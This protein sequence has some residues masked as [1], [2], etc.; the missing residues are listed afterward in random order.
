MLSVILLY[1]IGKY[2]YKLAE[3]YDKSQWSYAILGIAVFYAGAIIV[4]G[5]IM[6]IIEIF[7]PGF[8]DSYSENILG[9]MMMPFGALSCYLFYNL[10]EK[11]WKK[12]DPRL[13]NNIDDIGK[14]EQ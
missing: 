10:L 11:K 13:N 6:F 3:E 4:G 1:W 8:V 7:S 5:I 12:N 9:L 14:I 2:F